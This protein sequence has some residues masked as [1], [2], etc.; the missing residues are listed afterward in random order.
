M[1]KQKPV[2]IL[3]AVIIWLIAVVS[4][5]KGGLET[6]R[7]MLGAW[8]IPVEETPFP[9][10]DVL[11]Y[12]FLALV[13]VV[14]LYGILRPASFYRSWARVLVTLLLTTF[15]FNLFLGGRDYPPYYYYHIDWLVALSAILLVAEG[16]VLALKIRGRRLSQAVEQG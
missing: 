1:K 4:I 7:F 6:P 9:V 12:S 10:E 3:V 13:E 11:F 15:L 2:H 14:V 16:W 8:G 5:F